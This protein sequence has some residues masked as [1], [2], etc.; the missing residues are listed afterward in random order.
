[1]PNYRFRWLKADGTED[2]ECLMIAANDP[3][4]EEIARG[5]LG[6]SEHPIIE[7]WRRSK[8]IFQAE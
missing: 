3:E 2:A 4:A 6:H 5:L 7:V 1:M 8:R